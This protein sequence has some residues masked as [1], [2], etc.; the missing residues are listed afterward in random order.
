MPCTRP[1]ETPSYIIAAALLDSGD[2]ADARWAM[3]ALGGKRKRFHWKDA[4]SKEREAA[5][6]TV[7]ALPTLHLLVISSP[8]DRRR[9]ERA[10]AI[11]LQRMLFELGVRGVTRVCLESRTERLNQRDMRSVDAA[12]INGSI[13]AG[14]QVQHE[15][16]RDDPLLW[17]PDI[18][19]GAV[20]SAEGPLYEDLT[21][22]TE[23]VHLELP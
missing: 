16:P 2:C 18:V 3:E 17:I 13:D 12:M 4:T 14:M 6:S 10:R 9:Q 1:G 7:S 11:T 23:T 22:L 19:A 20:G 8:L 15:L 5:I 21:G